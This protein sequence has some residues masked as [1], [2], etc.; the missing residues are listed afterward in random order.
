MACQTQEAASVA[1]L[2]LVVAAVEALALAV[3]AV[4]EAWVP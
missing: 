4:S 1:A 3:A 2:V